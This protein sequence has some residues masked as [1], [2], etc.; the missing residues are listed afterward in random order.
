MFWF[1][2]DRSVRRTRQCSSLSAEHGAV[3][4]RWSRCFPAIYCQEGPGDRARTFSGN[5]EIILSNAGLLHHAKLADRSICRPMALLVVPLH[6]DSRASSRS[7]WVR[8]PTQN[9]DGR[10]P[11]MAPGYQCCSVRYAA[12][13]AWSPPRKRPPTIARTLFPLLRA[14]V[15]A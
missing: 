10:N 1:D 3:A 2:Q 5:G 6:I 11:K 13:A 9:I 8:R 14:G 15:R 7:R 4:Q 12:V